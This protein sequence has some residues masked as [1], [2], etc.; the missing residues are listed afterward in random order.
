LN[1]KLL[2]NKEREIVGVIPVFSKLDLKAVS[3]LPVG[4]VVVKTGR[5]KAVDGVSIKVSQ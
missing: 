4:H 2:C 5:K 1:S 3:G